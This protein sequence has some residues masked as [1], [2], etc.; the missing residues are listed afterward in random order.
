MS[1]ELSLEDALKHVFP[2]KAGIHGGE[3]IKIEVVLH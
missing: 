1:I 2:A 3:V